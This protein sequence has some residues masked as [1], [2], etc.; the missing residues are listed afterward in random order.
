[1][2]AWLLVVA[3]VVAVVVVGIPSCPRPKTAGPTEASDE[4]D[5][6][7]ERHICPPIGASDGLFMARRAG[8][9]ERTNRKNSTCGKKRTQITT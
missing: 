5:P 8:K 7:G 4:I 1:M 3:F 6:L 2:L 9:A